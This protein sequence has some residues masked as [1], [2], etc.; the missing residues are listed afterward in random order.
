M[1]HFTWPL[2]RGGGA[3]R[4]GRRPLTPTRSRTRPRC[5]P[6][7]TRSPAEPSRSKRRSARRCSS[8][9]CRSPRASA[10]RARRPKRRAPTPSPRSTRCWKTRRTH[11]I[12]ERLDVRRQP[13]PARRRASGLRHLA[14][15]LQRRHRNHPRGAGG[16]SAGPRYARQRSQRRPAR[17]Q[18][19]AAASGGASRSAFARG[20]REEAKDQ[21]GGSACC[22]QHPRSRRCRRSRRRGRR[23]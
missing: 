5:L 17:R 22:A 9:R 14:D 13:G 10:I 16:R 11:R 12:F 18:E 4:S 15:R 1:K 20:E 2:V 6:G 21:C 19:Q 3:A 23:S 8:A 7:S